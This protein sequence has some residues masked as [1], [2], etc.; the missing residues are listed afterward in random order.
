MSL[1]KHSIELFG[2]KTSISL[3]EEF[4]IALREIATEK[5]TSV[6]SLIKEIDSKRATPL[7]SSVRVFVLNYLLTKIHKK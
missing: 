7:S 6:L 4:W 5:N 1:K 3:E 2:H